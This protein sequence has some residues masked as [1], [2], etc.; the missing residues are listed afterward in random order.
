MFAHLS[1]QRAKESLHN[2]L[3]EGEFLVDV[4][5]VR[6][7]FEP[8]RLRL[9]DWATVL[10]RNFLVRGCVVGVTNR[11]IFF[12]KHSRL[13][14]VPIPWYKL[15]GAC[16]SLTSSSARGRSLESAPGWKNS[17]GA[18][19][20]SGLLTTIWQTPCGRGLRVATKNSSLRTFEALRHHGGCRPLRRAAGSSALE[21]PTHRRPLDR[22]RRPCNASWPTAADYGL[23]A[24]ARAHLGRAATEQ[25]AVGTPRSRRTTATGPSSLK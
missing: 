24:R 8:W 16:C 14:G 10:A 19:Y 15:E 12:L 11:R 4:S 25:R 7:S 23:D 5:P 22:D 20:T 3:E 18:G 2:S 21:L 17:V 13:L 6:I 1:R 9:P